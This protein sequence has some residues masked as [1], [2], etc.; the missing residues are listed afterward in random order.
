[1]KENW[2]LIVTANSKFSNSKSELDLNLGD[3]PGPTLD[4]CN[5]KDYED[6]RNNFGVHVILLSQLCTV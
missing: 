6:I 4:Y 1:M 5:F 2:L 3:V